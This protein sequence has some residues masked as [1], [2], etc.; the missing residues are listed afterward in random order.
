[1]IQEICI[2]TAARG[3]EPGYNRAG[4]HTI[5]WNVEY[6]ITIND[7]MRQKT[8]P[9]FSVADPAFGYMWGH[10]LLLFRG[11]FKYTPLPKVLL[12]LVL[13]AALCFSH[14]YIYM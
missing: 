13:Q 7:E 6:C 4:I 11:I 10:T 8:I 3:R 14:P 9:I 5:A 12:Q 2:Y 1:M